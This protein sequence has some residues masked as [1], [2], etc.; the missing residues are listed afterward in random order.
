MKNIVA[1]CPV[2]RRSDLVIEQLLNYKKVFDGKITHI[3][4]P[5]QEGRFIFLDADFLSRADELSFMMTEQSAKTSWKCVLPAFIE[6]SSYIAKLKGI[7]FVY[8]HT[9]GDLF[10]KGEPHEYIVKNRLGYSGATPQASWNWPHYHSMLN[11]KRFFM[12]INDLGMKREDILVGRQEGAFFETDLWLKIIDTIKG[13]YADPYFDCEADAWPLEEALV[14]T[15]A[16][17]YSKG[18]HVRNLIKT[19]EISKEGGRDNDENVVNIDDI[20]AILGD[21]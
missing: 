21:P 13:Y 3:L 17:F 2:H 14:P 8:I 18:E 6:A 16:R 12:M 10:I 1:L 20:K 5:S 11:D 7:D 19:K 9:D 4:H 15:L